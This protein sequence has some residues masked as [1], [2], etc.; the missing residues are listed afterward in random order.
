MKINISFK[1]E[2]KRVSTKEDSLEQ[3]HPRLWD[4]RSLQ[5]T[6]LLSFPLFARQNV[7]KNLN[8]F[9]KQLDGIKKQNDLLLLYKCTI[10]KNTCWNSKSSEVKKSHNSGK[11][12][13]VYLFSN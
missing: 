4:L 7:P 12:E 11:I 9:S 8:I 2:Q 13:D 10:F 6:Q 1:A 3:K 5:L